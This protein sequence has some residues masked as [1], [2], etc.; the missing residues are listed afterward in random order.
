MAATSAHE[1]RRYRAA[2]AQRPAAPG[3]L[4]WSEGM[5]AQRQQRG[6]GAVVGAG[7]WRK[8]HPG[9]AG[10]ALGWRAALHIESRVWEELGVK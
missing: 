1:P 4:L 9:R 7:V 2:T 10:D 5:A 8:G 6:R 3:Q